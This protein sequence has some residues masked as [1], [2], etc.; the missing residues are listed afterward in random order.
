M[1]ID[2]RTGVRTSAGFED[3][4]PESKDVGGE[5]GLEKGGFVGR[6]TGGY[7]VRLG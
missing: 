6:Y 3:V 1:R 7:H 2:A 5:A 4:G